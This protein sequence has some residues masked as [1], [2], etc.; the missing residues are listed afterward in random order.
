MR[1]ERMMLVNQVDLPGS[2]AGATKQVNSER[3]GLRYLIVDEGD[4]ISIRLDAES[5]VRVGGRRRAA[6]VVRVP[7]TNVACYV[8]DTSAPPIAPEPV[9]EPEASDA[10][11]KRRGGWPKGKPRKVAAE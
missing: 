5:L 8:L 4:H 1:I 2:D 10:E 11:P 3:N 9:P 7:L 6:D